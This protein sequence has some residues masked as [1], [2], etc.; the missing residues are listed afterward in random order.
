MRPRQISSR[1]R[2]YRD[3]ST[4]LSPVRV[5]TATPTVAMVSLTLKQCEAQPAHS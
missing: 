3:G 1:V 4:F 5:T 2:G